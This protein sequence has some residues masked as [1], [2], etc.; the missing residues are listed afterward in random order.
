[1]LAPQFYVQFD[2][3]LPR[4][5]EAVPFGLLLT[6]NFSLLVILALAKLSD[7][8][9]VLWIVFGK[10]GSLEGL[11]Q[12]PQLVYVASHVYVLL[13]VV[14]FVQSCTL[15]DILL[16]LVQSEFVNSFLEET[17]VE[18]GVRDRPDDWL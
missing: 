17:L 11:I 8:V 18:A 12:I 10:D 4:L 3:V 7:Q 14:E 6:V 15:A 5:P 1:M 16:V 13:D 2:V 9:Q